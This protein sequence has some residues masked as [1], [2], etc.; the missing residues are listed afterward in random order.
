[1]ASIAEHLDALGAI[2]AARAERRAKKPTRS[3]KQ[4]FYQSQP[5]RRLRYAALRAN[6]EKHGR[7]TCEVCGGTDGPW[8]CDH[9]IPLSKDWSRRL[10]PRNVQVMD[11]QC[12]LGKSNTDRIDWRDTT[13]ESKNADDIAA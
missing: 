8:H 3:V 5:W 9:I 1:V 12:N 6:R 11:A 2:E 13:E 4:T 7:L 10:D